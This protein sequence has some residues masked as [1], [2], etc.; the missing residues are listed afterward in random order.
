VRLVSCSLFLAWPV[1][2]IGIVAFLPERSAGIASRSKQGIDA[3][4][5][6]MQQFLNVAVGS[7]DT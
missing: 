6:H 3:R 7:L 2:I 4:H 5:V 1:G